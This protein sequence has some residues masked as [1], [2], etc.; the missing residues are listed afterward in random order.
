MM[1]F[2]VITDIFVTGMHETALSHCQSTIGRI[3]A[4]INQCGDCKRVAL[5]RYAFIKVAFSEVRHIQVGHWETC[6]VK[7][8]ADMWSGCM[9]LVR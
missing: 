6:G 5:I 4:T 8:Q 2:I 1:L 9:L 3:G 7:S